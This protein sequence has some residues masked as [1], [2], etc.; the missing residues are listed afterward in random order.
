[1]SDDS[2]K[3]DQIEELVSSYWSARPTYEAF[4]DNVG[5]LLV[6]LLRTEG[7]DH[8]PIEKR[9]KTIESFRAKLIRPEKE[10]KY[11]TLTDMTDLAGI[12][13]V[14]YY[15]KD[16][17]RICNT[18]RMNF[19][20][21]EANSTDKT[22]IIDPDRFGYL[23]KHFVV[24]HGKRRRDLPENTQFADLKAEIQI[25][26]VVQHAW[27]AID[28]RLRYNNE[29]DIPRELRRKLF[30]ISALLEL[31]DKE[32][33]EVDTAINTLRAQYEKGVRAGDLQI[34]INRD[35]VE[36][37]LTDSKTVA[38]IRS[39][40]KKFGLIVAKSDAGLTQLVQVISASGLRSIEQVDELLRS[41]K[42]IDAKLS[43]F[44]KLRGPAGMT[45]AALVRLC[46]ILSLPKKKA[47]EVIKAYPFQHAETS[48]ALRK[49]LAD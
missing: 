32:F 8:L 48:E 38:H 9:T 34:E 4:V 12:R 30:R 3:P 22:G 6:S 31:A 35:S 7:V 1:M 40:A 29:A 26:T 13:I 43:S 41:E 15:E 11:R 24:S 39:S 47:A 21:D 19:L 25:R 2:V 16:V 44:M 36:V 10:E 46:I 45:P 23:S 37:F 20:V 42:S 14:V 33:S 17:E 5:T 49:M 28:R 27:A 18:I